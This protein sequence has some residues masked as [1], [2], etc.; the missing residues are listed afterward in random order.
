MN[1][2]NSLLKKNIFHVYGKNYKTRDG[3]AIRD[4]IDVEDLSMIHLD[5]FRKMLISINLM[6]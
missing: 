4:F 6:K 2:T 1:L 5:V 3:T